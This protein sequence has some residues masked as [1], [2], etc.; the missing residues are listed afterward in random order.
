MVVGW[1]GWGGVG[2]QSHFRVKPNFCVEVVLGCRWDCDTFQEI[3]II[4]LKTSNNSSYKPVKRTFIKT[5][6][7]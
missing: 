4:V 5:Y 1:G 3:E 2:V 7:V 6:C